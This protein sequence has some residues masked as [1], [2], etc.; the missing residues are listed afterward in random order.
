MWYLHSPGGCSSPYQDAWLRTSTDG[1][2]W[3]A[4]QAVDL[5]QSGRVPW[6]LDV[7]PVD[8]G[9]A[10]IFI[11]YPAGSSCGTNN[12]Y[13]AESADGLSWT[14]T[15]EPLLTPAPGSWDSATI[16]R[17]SFLIDGS[18]LRIWYSARST[19]NQWRVG[20]T[21]GDLSEFV[22]PAQIGWDELR[23]SVAATT[24]HARSG[25]YGLREIGGSTY[26]QVFKN[27]AAGTGP[28]CFTAWTFDALSTTTDYMALLRMWDPGNATYPLH[29]IGTGLWMGCSTTHYS[30]H[31]EG[32]QYTPTGLPRSMGWHQLS[33]R[34]REATCDLLVNGQLAGSLDVLDETDIS[35]LSLEGY[36]GGTGWF[37]DAYVR[38]YAHPDPVVA[39][40]PEVLTGVAD[41]SGPV[42][43]SLALLSQPHP[44]PFSP[45]TGV[46]FLLKRPLPIRLQVFDLRGRLVRTLADE[47]REPGWHVMQWHGDDQQ[48]RRAP[49]G[50]YLLRLQAG[51]ELLTRKLLLTR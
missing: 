38:R 5:V 16:Y 4:P 48:G 36:R 26:P 45:D 22:A 49:A 15:P 44:N 10:M 47:V 46:R 1:T 21:E 11:S 42:A 37:D 29:A 6:H 14:V 50:T 24:D 39:V 28:V 31:T 27:V 8:G 2:S 18:W 40:G 7:Q 9:Y 43:S 23:G 3:S 19:G 30:Y 51:P 12:L 13:Y 32:W 41:E 17:A 20:Y 34:V 33:I 35:R 25:E